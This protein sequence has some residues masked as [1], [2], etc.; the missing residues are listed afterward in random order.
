[1]PLLA[2]ALMDGGKADMVFYSC[3]LMFVI[4][5]ITVLKISDKSRSMTV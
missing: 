5:I 2:G 4:A 1:M 3:A